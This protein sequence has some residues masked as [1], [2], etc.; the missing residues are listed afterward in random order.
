MK[1][2]SGQGSSGLRQAQKRAPELDDDDDTDSDDEDR[3]RPMTASLTGTRP[4]PNQLTALPCA[5]CAG[6]SLDGPVPEHLHPIRARV[7]HNIAL[8]ARFCVL[9]GL[10]G[11]SDGHMTGS[12]GHGGSGRG[13]E[14]EDA[15][16]RHAIEL[17]RIEASLSRRINS[18]QTEV[19]DLTED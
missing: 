19:I 8:V 1:G 3:K 12:S 18:T 16:V 5:L 10:P 11:A 9:A 7:C 15:A 17:S 13:Q 14:E 2:S 4:R 6:V